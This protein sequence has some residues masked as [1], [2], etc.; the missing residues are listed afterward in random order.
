MR[1]FSALF[2]SLLLM[3]GCQQLLNGQ[4][5]PVKTRTNGDYFVGC[6]GAVETWGSCNNKAMNTCPNGYDLISKEENSTGTVRELT[7]RCRK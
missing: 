7:F 4:Q 3:S 5:Q 2:I 1:T 6:G